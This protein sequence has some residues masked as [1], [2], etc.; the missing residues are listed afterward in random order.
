MCRNSL[1]AS[2]GVPSQLDLSL[3][4]PS[5]PALHLAIYIQSVKSARGAEQVSANVALG[6]VDRG[7]Q[8]DFL[9]EDAE[10]W[11]VDKLRRQGEGVRVINLSQRKG[12]RWCEKLVQKLAIGYNAVASPLGNFGND[13]N[14]TQSLK[15]VV[16][17][18]KPPILPLLRY[19][20]AE[21]PDAVLS[22]LNHPNL[23]LLLA[24]QLGPRRTRYVV[25]VRNH[26]STSAENAKSDWMRDVPRLMR[27]FFR[28]ADAVVAPSRGVAQDVAH[29]TGLPESRITAIP[30]PVYRSEIAALAQEPNEHPWFNQN[31]EPVILGVGKLKRQKDFPTLIKAFARVRAQRPAKLIIIGEGSD[32]E[33]LLELAEQLGVS[34]HVDLPGYIRN[35]YSFYRRASV[36]VLSSAWEGLP[37]ALIEALC[38]GAPVVSTD[39]PSGPSEILAD[40]AYGRLVP[41][42]DDAAMARA[43]LDTLEAPPKA[44]DMVARARLY[45]LDAAL[46]LYEQ[47]LRR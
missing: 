8:V 30:N 25:N 6:L 2:I 28:L 34:D 37:N 7:H 26:I 9:L 22:F 46:D 38:C 39:C 17:K 41:V 4:S 42:G 15:R 43:M 44:C 24:A 19:L 27:R 5:R 12:P 14:C 13:M 18:E 11:I 33:A 40:G 1:Y 29:I 16:R 47:V 45:S 3:L 31:E 32:R 36:F 23:V 35:P 20:Y 10:G 21:K